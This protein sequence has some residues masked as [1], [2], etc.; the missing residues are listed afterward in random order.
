MASSSASSRVPTADKTVGTVAATGLLIP[1]TTV[2]DPGQDVDVPAPSE[3][4]GDERYATNPPLDVIKISAVNVDTGGDHWIH[5]QWGGAGAGCR[6]SRKLVAGSGLL[7]IVDEEL[8][9]LG[10][11]IKAWADAANVVN[12]KLTKWPHRGRTDG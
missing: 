9:Q 3:L 11:P 8:V 7:V 4:L 1:L 6:I 12:V 2:A 10:T 5:V